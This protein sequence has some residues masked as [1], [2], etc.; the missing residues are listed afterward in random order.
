MVRILLEHGA[1]PE[2]TYPD[3]STALMVVADG[4]FEG[5]TNAL[6]TAEVLLKHGARVDAED[7]AGATAIDRARAEKF[8]EMVR[9]LKRFGAR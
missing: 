4:G 1:N 5:G 6:K 3:G 9:L 7:H 2:Q 8:L